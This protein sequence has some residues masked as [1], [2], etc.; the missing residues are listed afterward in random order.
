M[1]DLKFCDLKFRFRPEDNSDFI[2]K[3]ASE[4]L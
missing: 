1:M 3:I 4:D 2:L